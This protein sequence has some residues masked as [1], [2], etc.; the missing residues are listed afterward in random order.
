MSRIGE[1]EHTAMSPPVRNFGILPILDL[2]ATLAHCPAGNISAGEK[3]EQQGCESQGMQGGQANHPGREIASAFVTPRNPE[4]CGV[5]LLTPQEAFCDSRSMI[6]N[7]VAAARETKS[8]SPESGR[9]RKKLDH[10]PCAIESLKRS[11]VG[12]VRRPRPARRP[13]TVSRIASFSVN[14]A[15]AHAGSLHLTADQVGVQ[16]VELQES[17]GSAWQLVR[18]VD[19]IQFEILLCP[20]HR[21][22]SLSHIL[23]RPACTSVC[24]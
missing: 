20:E 9:K 7:L 4:S 23:L 6:Q 16:V 1:M 13:A 2:G 17:E 10:T 22:V 3:T 12:K 5:P 11:D 18:V 19:V 24:P 21:G 15:A 8:L 14:C